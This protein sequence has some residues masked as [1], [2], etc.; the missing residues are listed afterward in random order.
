MILTAEQKEEIREILLWS[1]YLVDEHGKPANPIQGKEYLDLRWDQ[2]RREIMNQLEKKGYEVQFVKPSQANCV[3]RVFNDVKTYEYDNKYRILGGNCFVKDITGKWI[4]E[5]SLGNPFELD[6][7]KHELRVW[8]F[9]D[10]YWM[11]KVNFF[12]TYVK[13]TRKK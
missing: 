8:F 2:I 7:E 10:E 13:L 1:F 9:Q 6:Y 5:S 4:S 12:D 11:V 3:I